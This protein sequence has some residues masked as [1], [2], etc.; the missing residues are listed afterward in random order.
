MHLIIFKSFLVSMLTLAIY[1]TAIFKFSFLVFDQNDL[2][3]I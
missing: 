2:T 3:K 1:D